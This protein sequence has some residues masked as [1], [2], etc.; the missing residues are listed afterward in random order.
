VYESLLAIINEC[1]SYFPHAQIRTEMTAELQL[2]TRIFGK[3][4][5]VYMYFLS[6]FSHQ[7]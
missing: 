1:R 6:R 4:E 7:K 2:K 5:A 3:L